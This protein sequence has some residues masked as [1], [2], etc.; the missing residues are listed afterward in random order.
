MLILCVRSANAIT[1]AFDKI[2]TSFSVHPGAN[3]PFH[4]EALSDAIMSILV[5]NGGYTV[6][7]S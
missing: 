1:P 3:E 5:S 4:N 2:A 6:A 7:Q